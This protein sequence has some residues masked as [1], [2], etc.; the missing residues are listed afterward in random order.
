MYRRLLSE[1]IGYMRREGKR[2]GVIPTRRDLGAAPFHHGKK[3]RQAGAHEGQGSR[4]RGGNLVTTRFM[5]GAVW[6][7]FP[8]VYTPFAVSSVQD[9]LPFSCAS[10]AVQF[11]PIKHGDFACPA[12]VKSRS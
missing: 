2:S 4:F 9:P 11:A 1:Q 5:V 3:G 6:F 7:T 8:T 10:E 12:G